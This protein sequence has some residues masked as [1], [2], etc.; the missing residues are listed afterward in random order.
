MT[1]AVIVTDSSRQRRA[2]GLDALGE[3]LAADRCD[4]HRDGLRLPRA[5][6][7]AAQVAREARAPDPDEDED[8]CRERNQGRAR[9][10][11][12]GPGEHS[13]CTRVQ[14]AGPDPFAPRTGKRG[15]R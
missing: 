8:A 10:G 15:V 9:G 2:Q 1:R 5:G 12:H 6:T 11:R 7:G 13:A 4:A 14:R 3:R